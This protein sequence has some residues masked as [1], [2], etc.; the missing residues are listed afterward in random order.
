MPADRLE[1][2]TDQHQKYHVADAVV[3]QRFPDD[4]GLKRLRQFGLG[5]DAQHGHRIGWRD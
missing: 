5:H 4:L 3:E 1:G 2:Q